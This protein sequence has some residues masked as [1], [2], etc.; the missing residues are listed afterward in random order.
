MSS[1]WV[2]Y[3]FSKIKL[4]KH[5]HFWNNNESTI[6]ILWLL[7]QQERRFAED[8][9]TLQYFL[10]SSTNPRISLRNWYYISL[11]MNGFLTQ[12]I[13]FMR[14]SS[15]NACCS[16]MQYLGIHWCSVVSGRRQRNYESDVQMKK[17]DCSTGVGICFA[18][19]KL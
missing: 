19:I 15:T 11:Q 3:R 13:F 2:W 17:S 8:L 14:V 5:R 16:E 10:L 9:Y 1:T 7:L 18:L 6:V 12:D 4:L